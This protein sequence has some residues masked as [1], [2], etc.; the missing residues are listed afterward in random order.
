MRAVVDANVVAAV[1]LPLPY[2]GQVAQRFSAWN[3]SGVELLAPTLL[4]YE[5]ASVLPKAVVAGW[6]TPDQAPEAICGIDTLSIEC[7]PPSAGLHERALRMAR[8]GMVRLEPS[9]KREEPNRAIR[10]PME[11][12]NRN[13]PFNQ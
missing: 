2:S 10:S 4:E 5:L 12:R 6:L 13:D 9:G 8:L 11:V 1:I 7:L 3:R